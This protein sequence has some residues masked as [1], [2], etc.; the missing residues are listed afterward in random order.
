MEFPALLPVVFLLVLLSAGECFG[1]YSLE[2]NML[3]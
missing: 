3:V 1:F 2:M